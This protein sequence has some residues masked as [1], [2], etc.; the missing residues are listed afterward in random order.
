VHGASYDAIQYAQKVFNTEINSVSD[1]PTIFPELD[2]II[3]AGNFHGQPLAVALD[4][5]AIAIAE[6]GSIA[7]RRVYKLISG[8]RDLPPFLVKNAGI[9]SGFMIPQYTAA[10]IASQNKQYCTPAVIDSI[11]SSNGQEDHVS[12]GA[13]SATK[14]YKVLENTKRILAIEL[15]NASQAIAFRNG[16]KSSTKVEALLTAFRKEVPF[17]EEDVQMNLYIAKAVAFIEKSLKETV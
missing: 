7:E 2:L 16:K 9:N 8:T 11:D 17:V 1:N 5:L 12:M 3:S 13:N 6:M 4:L 14:C 10:S 15:M